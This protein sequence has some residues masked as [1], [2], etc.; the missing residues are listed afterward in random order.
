MSKQVEIG[1]WIWSILKPLRNS[2][3]PPNGSQGSSNAAMLTETDV[4]SSGTATPSA[5]HILQ[6]MQTFFNNASHISAAGDMNFFLNDS[7]TPIGRSSE[8]RRP[9]ASTVLHVG[10]TSQ[11]RAPVTSSGGLNLPTD[12]IPTPH[13]DR[14]IYVHYLVKKGKGYLLWIPSPNMS[15][16]PVYRKSGVRV[17][18][19]GF[20]TLDGGFS[21]LFNILHEKT[22]AINKLMQLPDN[23]VTFTPNDV[24][25]FKDANAGGLLAGE[26]VLRVDSGDD[27]SKT[28]IQSSAA[29]AA[30][31]MLPEPVYVSRARRLAHFKEYVC[32]HL[33]SWYSFAKRDLGLEIRN[34]E[35]RVVSGC[36]KSAGFGIATVSNSAGA[37]TEL[38]FT[39]GDD[40]RGCKYHWH[41]RGH[42][43]TKAG[44]SLDENV[45]VLDFDGIRH[46]GPIINQCLFIETVDTALSQH[47]WEKIEI[48]V[49]VSASDSN[50][51][52]SSPSN[53]PTSYRGP[54][55]GSS[56]SN[57]SPQGQG[58]DTSHSQDTSALA[59]HDDIRLWPSVF[60][61][62]RLFHPSDIISDFLLQ[63][64]P[65]AAAVCLSSDNWGP[66][67]TDSVETV[68]TLIDNVL[69]FNEIC[70][71][72]GKFFIGVIYL[73]PSDFSV[74]IKYLE[75][76]GPSAVQCLW[77]QWLDQHDLCLGSME[78]SENPSNALIPSF[79]VFVEIFLAQWNVILSPWML[80]KIFPA[81]ARP[82]KAS[83]KTLELSRKDSDGSFVGRFT[84]A[85]LS[86]IY[87]DV[88]FRTAPD[89]IYA[90]Y[91]ESFGDREM[92][93]GFT[94]D[95]VPISTLSRQMGGS[96][97]FNLNSSQLLSVE[98]ENLARL[99]N[100]DMRMADVSKGVSKQVAFGDAF[101][102]QIKRGFFRTWPASGA[103]QIAAN[104]I[105]RQ[106]AQDSMKLKL[107]MEKL[108]MQRR[109][110]ESVEHQL[111]LE[112]R[113]LELEQRQLQLEKRQLQ[114]EREKQNVMNRSL[115][116]APGWK[117]PF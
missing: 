21:F 10:A 74:V 52:S 17:G 11:P 95:G 49:P 22:D 103:T 83:I 64:F 58:A 99:L 113:Q 54:I 117:I 77:Q 88:A 96:F 75:V 18:D 79:P 104:H 114:F 35:L 81:S 92:S 97:S 90:L 61:S 60:P 91:G 100:L 73:K 56:N 78:L 116:T 47:E 23:F 16:P 38:T 41:Y 98:A 66:H 50:H 94:G 65:Y 108:E 15:L 87:F 101:G 24:D 46:Q 57:I 71:D 44:P 2:L 12:P 93:F 86:E 110:L 76:A 85:P 29:Q 4:G 27:R 32:K 59:L 40:D 3:Y 55:L 20:L 80:T 89:G 43:E 84:L 1:L 72:N 106:M 115:N 19:V 30:A 14:D 105:E 8:A 109:Q 53:P 5:S 37:S 67:M 7:S 68:A 13:T 25:Q 48:I 28:V 26:L 69:L 82:L 51:L 6:R 63:A 39:V 107:E 70:E 34:G 9:P 36:R 45:D 33:P 42:A 31:L 112:E 102:M 62:K 111:E